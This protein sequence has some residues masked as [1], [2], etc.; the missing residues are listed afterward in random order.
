[1]KLF[2]TLKLI[3]LFFLYS[4]D[5]FATEVP[6]FLNWESKYIKLNP[7]IIDSE[8]HNAFV[9]IYV[10]KIAKSSYVN[11]SKTFPEGSIILKPL[12]ADMYRKEMARLVVMKKMKKGYD[13]KNSDW[14][15][16]VY[17]ETG[18]EGWYTG[19]IKSCIHCH[20]TARKTDYL[21]TQSVMFEIREFIDFEALD[22]S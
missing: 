11:S 22:D 12:Y 19:I 13:P 6:Q 5:I 14:W 1:M 21:F 20:E 9:D 8:G 18:T 17:D 15:Y 10:N 4:S 16:G 3:L 2:K 7:Q